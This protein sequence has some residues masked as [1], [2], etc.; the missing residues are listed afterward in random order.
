MRR[1]LALLAALLSRRRPRRR[2][3]PQW[4]GVWQGTV[5][6]LSGARC[7]STLGRRAGARL[8][9]LP[10]AA[11]ADR[12]ERRGRRG[13]LDRAGARRRRP[14]TWD[15]AELTGTRAARHLAPGPSQPAVRA[16]AGRVDR[17]RVGRPVQLGG[18]PA[19]AAGRRDDRRRAAAHCRLA[20]HRRDAT[21]PPRIL[22]TTWRSRASPSRR[23]AGRR[24]HRSSGSPSYLPASAS[25]T[26]FVAVPRR[27][28]RRG[29]T[30]GCFEQSVEPRM[31]ARLP[32]RRESSRHVLRRGASRLLYRHLTFDRQTGEEVDLL[33]W[34]GDPGRRRRESP[35]LPSCASWCRALAG[36]SRW[37][38]AASWPADTDVLGRRARARR[39]RVRARLAARRCRAASAAG[40]VERQRARAVPRIG[41][42]ARRLAMLAPPARADDDRLARAIQ[43]HSRGPLIATPSRGAAILRALTAEASAQR[44]DGASA[45][46]TTPRRQPLHMLR[47]GHDL[48]GRALELARDRLGPPAEAGGEEV[49]GH[50]VEGDVVGRLAKPWPS[51]GNST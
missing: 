34:L 33:D 6:T 12:A 4:V 27:R 48:R 8:V 43:R 42:A 46:R 28:D 13:R 45:G 37:R 15:F 20:L 51:S 1:L 5:G 29:G 14:R 7:A 32:G 3:R 22:P 21:G 36:R 31:A 30:D 26:T 16:R 19:A 2:T 17:G 35:C 44:T 38:N 10:V 39:P 18:V 25:A 9:L 41:R 49:L 23:T 47:P 24:G 40:H 11:R 50:R